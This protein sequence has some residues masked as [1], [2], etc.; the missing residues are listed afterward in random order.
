[1]YQEGKKNTPNTNSSKSRTWKD[2][3]FYFIGRSS[4]DIKKKIEGSIVK[5]VGQH[6]HII[7]VTT[8]FL[9]ELKTTILQIEDNLYNLS[10]TN[11][12]FTRKEK[13]HS[14]FSPIPKPPLFFSKGL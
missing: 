6:F 7:Q 4:P 1:M 13:A 9:E 2:F 8:Q 5:W 11:A 3:D 10:L 12:V 14:S